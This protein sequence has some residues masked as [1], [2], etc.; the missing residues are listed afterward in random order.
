LGELLALKIFLGAKKA[1][2]LI[3]CL[4]LAEQVSVFLDNFVLAKKTAEPIFLVHVCVMFDSLFKVL[5]GQLAKKIFWDEQLPVF[6]FCQEIAFDKLLPSKLLGA[7]Y[8]N[9]LQFMGQVSVLFETLLP[10]DLLCAQQVSFLLNCCLR[11]FW[12]K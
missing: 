10:S 6:F 5:G 4:L 12:A 3:N 9:L 2:V 11:I 7:K 1:T 8:L